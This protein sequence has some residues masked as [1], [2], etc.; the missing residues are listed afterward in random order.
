MNHET[1]KSIGEAFAE[2]SEALTL[3]KDNK[4]HHDASSAQFAKD[5]VKGH[6]GNYASTNPTPQHDQDAEK[7]HG[8]YD[9]QHTRKG[10]AGSGT[11]I[12]THKTTG[13]K[14]EVDRTPSGKGFYGTNHSVRKL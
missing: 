1:I 5:Y 8:T 7:F 10:F 3:D 14:F 11:S 4:V 13:E 12:Y 2:I 9:V 6:K